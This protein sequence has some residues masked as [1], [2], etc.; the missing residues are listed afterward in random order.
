LAKDLQ[1]YGDPALRGSGSLFQ[2]AETARAKAIKQF[3]EAEADVETR[4]AADRAWSTVDFYHVAET[5]GRIVDRLS[6]AER[7]RLDY[8][9][10]RLSR[11]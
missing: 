1:T 7:K 2:L 10:K 3:G 4:Q 9:R 6:A 11:N 5:Y 8:A